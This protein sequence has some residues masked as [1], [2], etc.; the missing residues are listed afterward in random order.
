MPRYLALLTLCATPVLA[1]TPDRG[2]LATIIAEKSASTSS[3][4]IHTGEIRDCTYFHREASRLDAD[5]HLLWQLSVDLRAAEIGLPTHRV[6]GFDVLPE[7]PVPEEQKMPFLIEGSSVVHFPFRPGETIGWLGF[8]AQNDSAI[9]LDARA[10]RRGAA[11]ALATGTDL[12]SPLGEAYV[13]YTQDNF[14]IVH[15]ADTGGA[16]FTELESA[17]RIWQDTWCREQS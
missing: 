12:H 9:R 14:R 4:G 7:P 15:H 11:R 13:G 6:I 8:T 3:T 17:L 16:D 10:E 2:T 1:E 5:T